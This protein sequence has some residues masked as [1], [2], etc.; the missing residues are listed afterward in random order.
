MENLTPSQQRAVVARGNVL[1]M[2]G[3]GTGK[4]HTLVARCLNLISEEKIS[5][6][7][8]LI[9][10][11]TE[12]AAPEMRQRLRAALEKKSRENSDSFLSEQ[13]ALFDAA[14]IGTL[15]G[16]CFKLIREHFHELGL[17]PQISILDE[18]QSR[19]LANETLEEQFNSH[20]ENEDVFSLAVQDL[21]KIYGS[22]R[23]E[24]I[25]A[26]I[27]RL[28]NY[29]QTRADAENWTARQIEIFSAAGPIQWREWFSAAI[30][31]WRTD[32]LPILQNLK[33]ENPKAAECLEILLET[34]STDVFQKILAT[35]ENWP[36][37]TKKFREPLK[38]FF[39]NAKFLNS[40]VAT[41]EN[42]PLAEDWNWIRGRMK[43]LLQLAKEFSEN[44]SARKR[45]D[46]VLDFHDLEQ[47][48]LK[49]LWNFEAEKPT[50]IAERWREKLRFVFVD[51]YQDINAAQD[52]IISALSRDGKNAN[53][54]LVGDVKQ[55]IY[56][57]R[58]ADQ[59]IFRNYA[60]TW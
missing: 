22:G 52:K 26:L 6:D 13:L 31:N 23:D 37:G 55:S 60:N 47:S 20:Y 1:V 35:D 3:A 8:I 11:F 32:W 49:L 30:A 42:D 2:A 16:F 5:L 59:K 56:R 45:D 41:D 39:D 54:F 57:F 46:G 51:E 36:R 19:M 28:H 27:L 38:D 53:R 7:E 14:H 15:H 48:A 17:D 50:P 34:N 24:K 44:F 25:R 58:L 18:G 33:A 10:T 40:L 9:V 21:I 4:T 12:A 43:T 29:I